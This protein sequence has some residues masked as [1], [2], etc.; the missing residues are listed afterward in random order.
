MGPR[1]QHLWYETLAELVEGTIKHA[2][3]EANWYFGT[4]SFDSEGSRTQEHVI[5]AKSL[6]LDLDAG[7]KKLEKH[8]PKKV[9]ATK[10]EAIAHVVDFAKWSN[11]RPS[12]IVDSGEG[13]HIYYCFD[14]DFPSMD[15]WLLC[16][17]M[18]DR[19]AKTFGLKVDNAVTKDSARVLRPV[20]G[21]HP[22]GAVVKVL[23][24][25]GDLT[26]EEFSAA[27][28]AVQHELIPDAAAPKA[29][30]GVNADV[31][32]SPMVKVE[33]SVAKVAQKCQWVA[34]NLAAKGNVGYTDWLNMLALYKASIEGVDGA[35]EWSSGHP[36]F[37]PAE[38][39]IKIESLTGGPP[40]CDRVSDECDAC[41]SC[42][43]FGKIKTPF[44]LGKATDAEIAKLRP[45][46]EAEDE[47]GAFSAEEAV[48]AD[49]K[50]DAF[51]DA[52]KDDCTEE[53]I[54]VGQIPEKWLKP[55][56]LVPF[57]TES[58]F[59]IGKGSHNRMVLGC[60]VRRKIKVEGGEVTRYERLLLTEQPFY[61]REFVSGG[62]VTLVYLEHYDSH[63]ANKAMWTET[64]VTFESLSEERDF[65]KL[66]NRLGIMAKDAAKHK[67]VMNMLHAY[68]RANLAMLRQKRNGDVFRHRFGFQF[69]NDEPV[70]VQGAYK[71][72]SDGVTERCFLS[73]SLRNLK[74][75][76]E[77]PGIPSDDLPDFKGDFYSEVILPKARQYC[78]G[79]KAMYGDA[80][81]A[82]LTPFALGWYIGV[83]S[84]Y[85]TFVTQ[86]VPQ[87]GLE[88]PGMGFVLSFYSQGSGFGKTALQRAIMRAYG[89][90]ELN[91]AGGD[92]RSGGSAIAVGVHMASR[93]SL[94]YFIDE[95]TN[96]KP[97]EVSEMIHKI[98]I[99]KDKVRAQR[100]GSAA[101]YTGSWT[102]IATMSS[103]RS[104]RLALTEHRNHSQA[105]Q[106]RLLEINF[107]KVD[108]EK[109]DRVR[110][111][112]S[113][114]KIVTP[115]TGALGMLLGRYGVMNWNAMRDR[116][117]AIKH[118]V[119]EQFGLTQAER[120][121]AAIYAAAKLAGE[122][123]KEVG[124][125][126]VDEEVMDAAFA[127][128]IRAIRGYVNQ[129]ITTPAEHAEEMIRTLMP[130]FIRTN[131]ETRRTGFT[132]DEYD[133]VHNL[134]MLDQKSIA[135]RYVVADNKVYVVYSEFQ[136]WCNEVGTDW[137]SLLRDWKNEGLLVSMPHLKVITAGIHPAKI[138]SM[139][140]KVI[141][142][143]LNRLNSVSMPT[144]GE[145]P[146]NI[147][148]FSRQESASAPEGD[149][150]ATPQ[151]SDSADR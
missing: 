29:S 128:V 132:S 118:K 151:R 18:L 60:Y 14:R 67:E 134:H 119:T 97:D 2:Y 23:K 144:E 44:S 52:A 136:Q 145:A 117:T 92:R 22:S 17:R 27:F 40:T 19:L 106:M 109:L 126:P 7:A 9:Y 71:V 50:E 101:T 90:S 55:T 123:M 76:Y 53:L 79:I 1:K 8:G 147:V 85:L 10:Q 105:E 69:L 30:S 138:A 103:N 21:L 43:H 46:A 48:V 42:E 12:L 94:P 24:S 62:S 141:E 124:I 83:A 104:L 131:T 137:R 116:A 68:T 130:R 113:M 4:T 57:N 33:S 125:L 112:E 37:D 82:S 91:K 150:H 81:N 146:D 88:M 99:G 72:N 56:E 36:E 65:R 89:D 6:R 111:E 73:G 70:Y 78:E 139:R 35:L 64:E 110:F 34:D 3:I 98:S 59:F 122:V 20:G 87:V 140:H 38:V 45:K 143:S 129:T 58:P 66:M 75:G 63:L 133:E 84:S 107:D 74:G 149:N 47:G 61:V 114:E 115:A 26:L 121:F 25:M 95:V 120:Y 49:K 100:D 127:D 39:T 102:S 54:A 108:P 80:S 96:N 93:G 51:K 135:G 5:A 11:L 15:V 41:R 77:I 28:K 13:L 86:E 16:A 148:H 32:A 142:L 31:L